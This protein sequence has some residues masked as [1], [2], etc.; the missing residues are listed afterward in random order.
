MGERRKVCVLGATGVGKTSLV[1]RFARSIF[2]ESYRTTIGVTIETRRVRSDDRELDLILWDLSGE[3]EF[4]DVQISYVRGAA[5]FLIVIDGTR[6]ATVE[7]GLRLHAAARGIAGELPSVIALNKADL[8]AAWEI[9]EAAEAR[10]RRAGLLVTRTSA[11]TGAGVEGAF[12]ALAR[13][14]LASEVPLWRG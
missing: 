11:R 3:D 4:Q 13:A 2:S 1:A 14:M 5:G 6:R 7:T 12:S 8:T 10:L 9:D